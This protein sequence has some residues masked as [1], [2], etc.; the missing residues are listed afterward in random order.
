M[1]A[2]EA[3]ISLR[4][5]V[6]EAT[7]PHKT[8]LDLFAGKGYMAW[9][10]AKHGCEKLICVERNREYF[11]VL[12]ENLAELSGRVTVKPYRMDNLRWL[13]ECLNPEEPISWV[14]FDAFG[15]PALQ[16]QKFFSRYPVRRMLTIAVTDGIIL[17]FR[18]LS[19]ANLRRLYLQD[20]YVSPELGKPGEIGSVQGLGEYWAEIQ[21]GLINILA[22]RFGFQAYPIFFKVNSRATAIYSAYLCL[23]KLR[24][25]ADFKR[26]AGLRVVKHGGAIPGKADFKPAI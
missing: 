9:L 23:P 8:V 6:Y 20:F 7:G 3:K 19:N 12:K 11:K 16:I 21:K 15:S 22:M 13:E 1:E 25:V 10:Y 26:Y 5:Q 14:D 24:G 17:N 4:M 2:D 18:R